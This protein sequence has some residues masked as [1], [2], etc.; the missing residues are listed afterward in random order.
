MNTLI[1]KASRCSRNVLGVLLLLTVTLALSGCGAMFGKEANPDIVYTT[2]IKQEAWGLQIETVD[3][4]TGAP[5][6]LLGYEGLDFNHTP[7]TYATETTAP[8][9]ATYTAWED[10]FETLHVVDGLSS[11]GSFGL[12]ASSGN[13]GVEADSAKTFGVGLCGQDL[14]IGIGQGIAGGLSGD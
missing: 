3:V 6:F 11:C 5:D 8:L 14:G 10:G 4:V 12:T 7:A 1:S 13:V 9:Q 2:Y